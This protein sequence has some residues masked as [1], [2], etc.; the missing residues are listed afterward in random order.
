MKK[1]YKVPLFQHFEKCMADQFPTF[2][3]IPSLPKSHLFSDGKH[4]VEEVKPGKWL[5]V[6]LLPDSRG[7]YHNFAVDVGWS[8]LGRIPEEAD[9]RSAR[10]FENFKTAWAAKPEFFLGLAEGTNGSWEFER[11]IYPLPHQLSGEP[12]TAEIGKS[13]V[14]PIVDRVMGILQHDGAPVLDEMRARLLEED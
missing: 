11:I 6:S 13:V 4:F 5:F 1:V 14:I 3:A 12:I 2:R 10:A 9:N 8:R 7:G